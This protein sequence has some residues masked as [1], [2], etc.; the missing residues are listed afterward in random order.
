MSSTKSIAFGVAACVLLVGS[1]VFGRQQD[2]D[3]S[4]IHGIPVEGHDILP[5]SR[6]WAPNNSTCHDQD[7]KNSRSGFEKTALTC[8]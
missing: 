1:I 8:G 4:G 6:S 5:A 7:G 2:R 3:L